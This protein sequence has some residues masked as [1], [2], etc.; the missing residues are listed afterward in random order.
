M[1]A[2][3]EAL[4]AGAESLIFPALDAGDRD[5]DPCDAP[6]RE[7]GSPPLNVG[8]LLL[9]IVPED[10]A[11]EI[12]ERMK[13]AAAERWGGLARN[14]RESHDVQPL[15]AD[16][17]D[18]IWA[19]Q[20]DSLLEVYAVACPIAAATP[21]A[22]ARERCMEA[23]AARKHL[24]DFSPWVNDRVGAPKS[25]F[26]G[27]RVSIL[28]KGTDRDIAAARRRFRLLEGE[29]LDAVG[30]VKR[31]GGKPEQFVPLAN[32]ALA[33]WLDRCRRRKPDALEE[34]CRLCNDHGVQ[35]VSRRD[36]GWLAWRNDGMAFD[37][38]I[39]LQDRLKQGL[40]EYGVEDPDIVHRFH[41]LIDQLTRQDGAGLP[42]V[43]HVCCL[44]ADGDHMGTAL[45]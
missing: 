17:I 34:L 8:N 30:L 43:P 21:Y 10:R 19:E 41:E 44:V 29:Q 40:K 7:D 45:S 13:R 11:A 2:A 5:L 27:G 36:L 18:A 12:A 28:A 6:L 16:G 4:A 42:P 1:G 39:L 15:L 33:G 26:D 37:G 38:E 23:L 32:V 24:S 35:R 20:I 14:V 22:T 3:K 31:C 25:S 9:L